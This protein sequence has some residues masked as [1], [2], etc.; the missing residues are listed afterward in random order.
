MFYTI[1]IVI[2][3]TD[4]NHDNC[5]YRALIRPGR[6]DNQIHLHMPD[7]RARLNILKVHANKVKLAPGLYMN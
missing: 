2:Q 4:L 7:V 5:V 6:F 3:I 1:V